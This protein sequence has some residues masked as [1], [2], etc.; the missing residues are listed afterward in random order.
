M[1][2]L[3]MTDFYLYRH[4]F[5]IGYWLIAISL[6]LLLAVVTLYAPGG[7]ASGEIKS[8]VLGSHIS[9]QSLLGQQADTIAHLPYLALQALS[10]NTLG[11]NAISIKLP[12]LILAVL[13]VAAFFGLMRLWFR[14]N[15][16]V[17]TTIILVTT[18]HFLLI[19][20]LGTVKI[21]YLFFNL[22]LLFSVSMMTQATK[23]RPA[24]L[25]LTAVIA[26]L[27]LYAPLEFYI[28]I[29]LLVI[30]LVHPHARFIVLKQPWWSLVI[31]IIAFIGLSM[32]LVLGLIAHPDLLPHFAGIRDDVGGVTIGHAQNII[33]QYIGFTTPD[34][35]E[36]ITPAYGVGII[37]LAGIGF[38]RMIR[39]K[40]T[41]KS[42]IISFWLLLLV[43]LVIFIP[44]TITFSFVPIMLLVAFAV[45]YLIKSW[46]GLFPRNPYARLLGLVPLAILVISLSISNVSRFV[47][48]YHY[49]PSASTAFT[50][51][52]RL[53]DSTVH[54]ETILM[55]NDV[56]IVVPRD[57]VAFYQLYAIR[58]TSDTRFVVTDNFN[59][60]R[61]KPVQV[62][63]VAGSL[64][65]TS[66]QPPLEV[67]TTDTAAHADRFYVYSYQ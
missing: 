3:S 19:S 30:S 46:Y 15:V 20:Q 4:R 61:T 14:R 67:V 63:I 51:D 26:A 25:I 5:T 16:A 29:G 37:A 11:L 62:I 57:Q 32:P 49:D 65:T 56:T 1:G 53:L 27:S 43:P 35:G 36:A 50:Q 10:V 58:L 64:N 23:F 40:Y 41:A 6:L 48:G 59:S 12:S 33:A 13:S 44:T 9:A 18:G 8:V 38:Y 31:A 54:S 28:V 66:V 17:I 2:K 52:L 55:A 45:N 47:Y 7:I 22:V 39:T 42:Y 24:W 34:S 21:T 60:A